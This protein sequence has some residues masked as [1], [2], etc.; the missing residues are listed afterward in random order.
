M[1]V[2]YET[3]FDKLLMTTII[4]VS[5][6]FEQLN[7]FVEEG[8]EFVEFCLMFQGPLKNDSFVELSMSTV[9]ATAGSKS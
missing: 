6:G 5:V 9:E 2:C 1:H 3:L 8:E 4:G 7:Y